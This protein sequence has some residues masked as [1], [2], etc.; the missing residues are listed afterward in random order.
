MGIVLFMTKMK[1]IFFTILLF[2]VSSKAQNCCPEGFFLVGN[3]C[4]IAS[5]DHMNWSQA[6]EFCWSKGG[7]LAEF[8]SL[9]EEQQIDP[10]LTNGIKYWIGLTDVSQE[11]TWKWSE[12]HKETVYTNWLPNQPDNDGG[13]E[14]CACKSFGT[15]DHRWNDAPCDIEHYSDPHLAL[16]QLA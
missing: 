11:G 4:Y 3:K 2:T 16:C 5:V 7:Y 8:E 15:M 14:N 10:F 6:Q 1:T 9:E 12:S 13:I